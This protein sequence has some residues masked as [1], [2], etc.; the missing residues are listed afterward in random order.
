MLVVNMLI[1]RM[2]FGLESLK[3][4]CQLK[5][6]VCDAFNG[7]GW[8]IAKSLSNI[9]DICNINFIDKVNERV[10]MMDEFGFINTKITRAFDHISFV[11]YFWERLLSLIS[12]H[13]PNH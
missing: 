9:E 5:S 3:P 13:Q 1:S 4:R 6:R 8:H 10:R 2:M 11:S 7:I 12:F